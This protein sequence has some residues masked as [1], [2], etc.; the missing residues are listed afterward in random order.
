MGNARKAFIK[1]VKKELQA[2]TQLIDATNIYQ[3]AHTQK[4]D[5]G[6][7]Y[8]TEEYRKEIYEQ[9]KLM[10]FSA[11]DLEKMSYYLVPEHWNQDEIY[12]SDDDQLIDA[13]DLFY[14]A[15]QYLNANIQKKTLGKKVFDVV[16]AIGNHLD[17]GEEETN[18]N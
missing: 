7:I 18:D 6:L 3:Q 15:E 11:Q 5:K 1:A 8:Y 2:K 17:G 16:S 14:K 12:R 13:V 4:G 10:G 9:A